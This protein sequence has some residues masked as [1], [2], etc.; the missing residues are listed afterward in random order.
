M[1]NLLKKIRFVATIIPLL[2][3][4]NV[5]GQSLAVEQ[6]DSLTGTL[7]DYQGNSN[8]WFMNWMSQ[9]DYTGPDGYS[10]SDAIPMT[11]PEVTSVGN[12]CVGGGDFTSVGRFFDVAG[13]FSAFE[14]VNGRIGVGTLY[15]SL[16]IRKDEDNDT[17]IEIIL[18][19]SPGAAW[20]I[21]QELIKVGYFGAPSNSGGE[22]YWS[23]SV[24]DEAAIDLSDTTITIGV[25]YQIIV[26]INFTTTTDIN[27]WVNPTG[28][29]PDLNTPDATVSSIEDLGFWNIVL[30]FDAL[31]TGHGGFDEFVFSDNLGIVLPVTYRDF[32]AE[33]RN[34]RIGLHWST[35]TEKSNDRF[36]V[37][38]SQTGEKWGTIGV[39]SG[40]GDSNELMTY[41]F[42]DYNPL[43]GLNYYR[44]IQV[45]FDGD[46]SVS[47]IVRVEYNR[48]LSSTIRILKNGDELNFISNSQIKE[49]TLIDL[50]GRLLDQYFPLS[51]LFSVSMPSKKQKIILAIVN[52]ET[53][54]FREKILLR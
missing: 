14:D 11:H 21:N 10:I 54:V 25:T 50:N 53:G 24:F 18:A 20:T 34:E 36:I 33:S 22:R 6:F 5:S 35:V 31:G 43:P 23:V 16:L 29:S 4:L 39:V 8:G 32:Y 48:G 47:K 7:H 17:P 44:L 13:E 3:I 1:I 19:D 30:F 15:F 52:T 41:S 46:R 45:D 42:D 28:G 9:N 51:N 12:Y 2:F 49:I 40:I 38:H 27:I 26:E 37:Q